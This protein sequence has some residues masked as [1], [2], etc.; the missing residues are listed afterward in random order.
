M[1]KNERS[2]DVSGLLFKLALY[3]RDLPQNGYAH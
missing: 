2:P 1:S 3:A